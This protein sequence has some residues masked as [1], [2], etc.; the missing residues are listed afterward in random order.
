LRIDGALPAKLRQPWNHPLIWPIWIFIALFLLL[1]LPL[2]FI[3]WRR[4]YRPN[5]E[6]Y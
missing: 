3:Y 2:F 1:L 6:R 4:E 5:V